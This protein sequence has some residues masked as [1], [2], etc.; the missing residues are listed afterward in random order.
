M[1]TRRSRESVPSPLYSGERVRVRGSCRVERLNPLEPLGAVE[2]TFLSAFPSRR[3]ECLHH[4][5]MT[6]DST[7]RFSNRVDH[8]VKFRP[9]YPAELLSFLGGAIGLTPSW[10]VA[11]VGAGTGISAEL[12]LNHGNDV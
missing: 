7:T 6:P 2:Q 4:Q 3:Q 5:P 10:R 1:T 9:G 12:F 8:Y 11:D